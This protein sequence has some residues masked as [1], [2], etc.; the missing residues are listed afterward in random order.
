MIKT[1][2]LLLA[3][4]TA[5]SLCSCSDQEDAEEDARLYK[6]ETDTAITQPKATPPKTA[7][8]P[9]G[10]QTYSSYG[11]RN[12][13]QAWKIYKPLWRSFSRA[14]VVFSSGYSVPTVQVALA[15]RIH[16]GAGRGFCLRPMESSTGV[17]IQAPYGDHS[18]LVKICPK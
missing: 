12:G 4:I 1:T 3:L 2:M 17:F 6:G 14:S 15:N 13:R 10:C 7:T 9:V 18:T 5:L 8:K 11:F 16:T